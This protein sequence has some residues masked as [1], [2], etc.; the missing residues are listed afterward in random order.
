[1]AG[2]REANVAKTNPVSR[3]HAAAPTLALRACALKGC[4]PLIAP[5][6][7]AC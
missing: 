2:T 5:H 7:K 3:K 1:M 4:P 6:S